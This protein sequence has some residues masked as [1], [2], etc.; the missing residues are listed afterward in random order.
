MPEF[1]QAPWARV[2]GLA[3][4]CIVAIMGPTVAQAPAPVWQELPC[5]PADLPPEALF[6]IV[7]PVDDFEGE[8]MQWQ[9]LQGGQNATT[10]L[11]RDTNEKHSGGAALRVDYTFVGNRDYEYLQVT[12]PVDIPEPGLGLGFWLKTDGTPFPMRLRVTDATGETHQMDMIGEA[13]AGWRFVAVALDAPGNAWGG[14]G[15]RRRDYPLQLGG[16]CVDRTARDY[17]AQGSLWIDDVALLTPR[18]VS[19]TLRVE[20]VGK[21][22][23]NV[24]EPGEAVALRMSGDG[25]R[26]N[27]TLSDHRGAQIARGDGP[28][29]S[30]EARFS[31][32]A[33]GYYSCRIELAGEGGMLERQYFQAAALPADADALMSDFVGLNCHFGQNA[34]PLECMQLMRRYGIDR[35]RDEMGWVYVER[36]KGQYALPEH[37]QRYLNHADQLGMRP[38]VIF[39]YN[40]QHY[41][42]GGFPNSPEAIA[43]FAGYAANLARLTRGVVRDFEVWNEWIGGCG[44]SGRPGDHGPEAYGKLLA[45]TYR[46]VKAQAPDV[47]VVGVGGEYGAECVQNLARMIDTAG[48]DAMDAFSIHPYRYPRSPEESDLVG[49]VGRIMASAT[50]HGAAPKTWITEIG[51][52]THRGPGGSDEPAQARHLIRTLLL[53]QATRGVRRVYWYDLKDDGVLREYNEHNFG[54]VHHQAYNCAPKPAMVALGAFARITAR[55]R[56]VGLDH[57]G[58]RYSAIYE[59]ADGNKLVVAWVT[60]RDRVVRVTGRVT[61]AFDLMGRPVQVGDT[62]S[63]C[64]RPVY[65]CGDAPGLED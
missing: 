51:Y 11:Q 21:R 4:V 29:A 18:E 61:S 38:L 47:T 32:P 63:L 15:N 24:Y 14:D 40:N 26:I 50:D 54:V 16:I 60:G 9:A 19:D 45:A 10:A 12:R 55:S 28:A 57:A 3:L 23:G 17:A 37:L 13:C 33:P 5:V 39:D 58:D 22:F 27:W 42:D 36:D 35:F 34:Y 7:R 6:D 44:M 62:L 25:A 49:E 46:A 59:R 65:L 41:D 52:P 20:T 2:A 48:P 8:Q 43:G 56:F 64:T 1:M 53:L 30:T 31:F